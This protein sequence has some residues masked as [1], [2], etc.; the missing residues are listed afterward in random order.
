MTATAQDIIDF[1]FSDEVKKLWFNSNPEFDEKI[2]NL[3]EAT[4]NAGASGLLKDWQE[5]AQG[6]LALVILFDQFPLNMYRGNKKGFETESLSRDIAH[7]AID[8]GF[9]Q[10]MT[11]A[12]KAFLYMPFMHSENIQDQIRSVSLFEAANLQDNLRFAKHHQDIVRRFGRFPHRNKLLGRES[13]PEEL[14]YLNS[15]SAFHG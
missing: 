3:F 1:W 6:T 11:G 5:T 10:N 9:D 14:E 12:E 2:R 13:T 8:K 7:A 15:D 4:Y